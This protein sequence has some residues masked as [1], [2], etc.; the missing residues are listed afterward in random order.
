MAVP[1]E[2][3][4]QMWQQPSYEELVI[5][6]AGLELGP[7][8]WSHRSGRAD[9]LQT[10]ERSLTSQLKS[11]ETRYISSIIKS[12]LAWLSTD[13]E[14]E[15]V[16]DAAGRRMSERCGRMAVGDIVRRWP[17]A[18]D[19]TNST[20]PST[21]TM[22]TA[23]GG[24]SSSSSSSEIAVGYEPFELV[25]REPALNGDAGLGFKTWAS[26][27]VLARQLPRLAASS[28][29]RLF[30][31]TLG[32]P[33]PGVLELGSGTG[34]LGLAAAALW[35]VPVTL[36]DLPAIVPNLRH[37]AAGNKDA[38]AARGGG[39]VR[40]GCLTWGSEEDAARSDQ[41]LF[42]EPYQFPIVLAADSLYNDNHPVLLASAISRNLA[43][44]SKSRVLVMS[45]KRDDITLRLIEEFKQ[46]ML[47]LE[48]PL[49]CEEEDE[50]S[51]NDDWA[52]DDN[53]DDDKEEN[54]GNV[55]CWLGIFSRGGS[56]LLTEA[57]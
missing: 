15:V 26:S 28:L 20:A 52:G 12:P 11:E 9:I 42:G 33:A 48:P 38:V 56:P 55:R 6:L 1:T 7:T 46:T 10:Q 44:G 49:F 3:L 18:P 57:D 25:I 30:D 51:G 39:E 16:W 31:E 5:T 14:R 43:L 29:F 41:E 40:L 27:Y 37:N 21:T 24:S 4:P 19:P 13:D 17:F 53:D 50:F 36:S 54:N 8:V 32:Q 22:P 45:P 23:A 35:K 2:D 34:L 47:D